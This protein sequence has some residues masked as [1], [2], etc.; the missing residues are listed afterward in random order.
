MKENRELNEF[1]LNKQDISR[2]SSN[3]YWHCSD[4]TKETK[5]HNM[6][7]FLSNKNLAGQ[8]IDRHHFYDEMYILMTFFEAGVELNIDLLLVEITNGGSNLNRIEHVI[9]KNSP[10]MRDCGE[11]VAHAKHCRKQHLDE[12]QRIKDEIEQI[13][14]DQESGRG[15]SGGGEF[16]TPFL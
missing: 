10:L 13:Y 16:I 2:A 6:R 8:I 15:S 4:E 3:A 12:Q 11:L 14:H 1:E 9:F 5:I 7:R